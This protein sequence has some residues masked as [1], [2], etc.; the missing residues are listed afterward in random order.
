MPIVI[1]Q[2]HPLYERGKKKFGDQM[3]TPQEQATHQ[4]R[5]KHVLIVNTMPDKALQ[6]TED[7]FVE[8]IL[9]ASPEGTIIRLHFAKV[10]GFQRDHD[11]N[12]YINAHYKEFAEIKEH[13]MDAVIFTGM[14]HPPGMKYNQQPFYE[15]LV[16]MIEW[17]EENTPSSLFSCAALHLLMEHKHGITRTKLNHKRHGFYE[18]DILDTAH[19]LTRRLNDTFNAAHSRWHEVYEHE[20]EK[21]GMNILM[22]SEE[23]GV[24]LVTSADGLNQVGL[25]GHPE[26]K[27]KALGAEYVRDYN[28]YVNGET[29]IIP[30]LPEHY[31][32]GK[33]LEVATALH[34]QLLNGTAEIIRLDQ[35]IEK[36][37]KSLKDIPPMKLTTDCDALIRNWLSAVHKTTNFNLHEQYMDEI[38]P[39]DVF[40]RNPLANGQ[41]LEAA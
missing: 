22:K 15:P 25:Q 32:R 29:T 20:F 24:L 2:E 37:P 31:F 21:A 12:T 1:N 30:T 3:R 7:D 19:P 27:L 23:A 8:P 36:S 14:N 18:H 9:G 17:A 5:D 28:Q 4:N 13:G 34:E 10:N 11:A 39:K 26:Y 6:Q 33:S 40:G 35:I 38:N 16:E 41:S